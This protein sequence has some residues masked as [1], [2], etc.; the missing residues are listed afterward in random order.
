MTLPPQLPIQL[1]KS[2]KTDV[3][4]QFAALCF[5]MNEGEVE[6]CLVTSR[7]TGRWI[8]PKGWPM[9]N[10][11]PADAA[12][13]E[14]WEEA[15]LTGVAYDRC[16]GVFSY[17]KPLNRV[18]AAVVCML[19]PVEV[20]HEHAKWPERKQRKRQWFTREEAA[21]AVAEKELKAIIMGFDP[22]TLKQPVATPLN[23]AG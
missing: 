9:H 3:R 12:A 1:R 22:E 5:R 4:S 23:T 15:G 18:T 2:R 14:A 21:A 19:Y 6:F 13:T 7:G 20:T 17:L 16:L 8:T 10:Q 11:T